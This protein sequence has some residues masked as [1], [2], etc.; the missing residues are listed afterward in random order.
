MHK[1]LSEMVV[2]IA[3][4]LLMIF[5]VLIQSIYHSALTVYHSI[6]LID[7]YCAKNYRNIFD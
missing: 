1:G 2:I 5:M 4:G 3:T 7:I 6:D